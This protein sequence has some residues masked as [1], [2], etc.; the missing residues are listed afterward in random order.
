MKPSLERTLYR[1]LA[2]D[3][4]LPEDSAIRCLPATNYDSPGAEV[5]IDCERCEEGVDFAV[6]H[7]SKG[8]GRVLAFVK[9]HRS[10]TFD[11]D[12]QW[13]DDTTYNPGDDPE[14]PL[15]VIS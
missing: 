6:G 4:D 15:A 10:C 1:R 12:R 14:E 13:A 2:A 7:G 8:Y 3:A 11:P 5:F 9:D